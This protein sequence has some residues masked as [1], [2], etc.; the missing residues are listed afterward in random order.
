M[1]LRDHH[2]IAVQPP[3]EV[4]PQRGPV[5]AVPQCA[6]VELLG[7][8]RSVLLLLLGEP[9]DGTTVG[10]GRSW[11]E[12][13]THGR[14]LFWS[15]ERRKK[16]DKR[17]QLAIRSRNHPQHGDDRRGASIRFDF[18]FFF[19]AMLCRISNANSPPAT[20]PSSGAS[21]GRTAEPVPG[22][23]SSSR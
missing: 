6:P 7:D 2:G 20:C 17:G 9:G 5:V 22:S 12:I 13:R 21:P 18:G 1:L 15:G 10:F 3:G 23:P 19:D 8:G 4:R 16:E 14:D 11:A